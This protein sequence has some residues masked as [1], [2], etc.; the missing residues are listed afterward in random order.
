M[1]SKPLS[2]AKRSNNG[3]GSYTS[4]SSEHFRRICENM[5]PKTE[6]RRNALMHSTLSLRF[7]LLF[8]FLASFCQCCLCN[9]FALYGRRIAP[10][11]H[12][13]RRSFVHHLST[14]RRVEC[15]N[16]LYY[17]GEP[18]LRFADKL[19]M[20]M[21]D[22]LQILLVNRTVNGDRLGWRR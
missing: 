16:F 21:G 13:V 17:E 6:K 3:R 20:R 2:P 10:T 5:R 9:E 12:G 4:S 7:R 8:P 14:V 19:I 11:D 15:Q 18:I 1:K 22:L